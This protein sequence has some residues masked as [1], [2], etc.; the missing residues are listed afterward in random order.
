MIFSDL[1]DWLISNRTL[2]DE[3]EL[4]GFK[5]LAD[6]AVAAARSDLAINLFSVAENSIPQIPLLLTIWGIILTK[7]EELAMP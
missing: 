7:L 6:R 4:N 3:F 1:L 2:P 5:I